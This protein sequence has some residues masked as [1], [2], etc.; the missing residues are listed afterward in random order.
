MIAGIRADSSESTLGF[1]E[2]NSGMK[3]ECGRGG[4]FLVIGN[5]AN[6]KLCGA[7]GRPRVSTIMFITALLLSSLAGCQSRRHP[8]VAID[9]LQIPKRIRVTSSAFENG[10][11]I[12]AANSSYGSDL[13]P[14]LSWSKLPPKTQSV[15][16]M[17]QDPD[18][19]QGLFTHWLLYNISPK[20][21]SLPAGLPARRGTL[22]QGLQGENDSGYL[23]YFGPRPPD[24]PAHHYH[25]Q[26]FALD[27][28]LRP[29]PGYDVSLVYRAIHDHAI[30]G[31]DLVGLFKKP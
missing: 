18:T 26:V 20:T 25:F 23:G 31:G 17:V 1:V 30:A 6:P 5:A 19:A 28:R 4:S 29:R 21:R 16:V 9:A 3:T 13:S 27:A 10:G 24:P 11:R 15:I 8:L 12:P 7:E 22:P 14:D 2:S